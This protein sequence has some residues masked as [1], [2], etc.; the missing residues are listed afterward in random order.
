MSEEPT[1]GL[2]VLGASENAGVDEAEKERL[3]SLPEAGFVLETV[4]GLGLVPARDP[5]GD[6]GGELGPGQHP[7]VAARATVH[8]VDRGQH[9]RDRR[10]QRLDPEPRRLASRHHGG[11]VQRVR[12]DDPNALTARVRGEGDEEKATRDLRGHEPNGVF[13][14]L[15]SVDF[16]HVGVEGPGQELGQR[17]L[18]CQAHLH[19][20]LHEGPAMLVG[21]PP[22]R[23]HLR[24]IGSKVVDQKLRELHRTTLR[25]R[26][27]TD[28]SRS[29]RIHH[30]A[31]RT[32]NLPQLEAFYTGVLGLRLKRKRTGSVWLEAGEAV[33]M[34]EEG[35]SA[36]PAIPAG[37]RELLAFRIEPLERQRL[38]ERLR[39]AGV[40]I[41]ARTEF[42]DY[43][44]D[45]DGRRVAVSRHP[46]A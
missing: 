27:A 35:S 21:Q 40:P 9:P 28:Y 32:R 26:R 25:Q 17:L 12:E 24:L 15:A 42:T 18:L 43:F 14:E 44:R 34:L 23:P 45:P 4:D 36:E 37:S 46:L 13:V 7:R 8:P 2:Q 31:L 16:D 41:E 30:L 38:L 3:V 20:D 10:H 22:R 29:M 19:R 5:A 6:V 11:R 1:Q 39:T 33:L